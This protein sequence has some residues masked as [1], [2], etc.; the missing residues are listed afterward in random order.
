MFKTA[1]AVAVALLLSTAGASAQSR[2]VRTACAD[3][4]KAH[5]ADVQRGQ[6]R[7]RACVKEHFKDLSPGCQNVLVQA[8]ALRAAC[9]ADAKQFCADVRPGGRRIA[10]CLDQHTADLSDPCKDA[11]AQVAAGKN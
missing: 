11:M 4:I 3:D 6:G 7:I 10:A 8:E 2:A 5:C 9:A 1:F